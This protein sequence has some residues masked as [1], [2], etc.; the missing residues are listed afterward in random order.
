[1]GICD[2]PHPPLGLRSEVIHTIELAVVAAPSHRLTKRQ[3]KRLRLQ[4]LAGADVII[5]R[6][7][8]GTRDVVDALLGPFGFDPTH[9]QLEVPSNAAARLSAVNGSGLA[10]LPTELVEADL[11]TGRLVRFNVADAVLEQPVRLVWKGTRPTTEAARRLRAT[12]STS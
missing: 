5:R 7:G 1:M 11:A 6:S 12:L 3:R 2:G 8:S 10:I 4:E 9:R